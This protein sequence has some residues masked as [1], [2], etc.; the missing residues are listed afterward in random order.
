M[1]NENAGELLSYCLGHEDGCNR[2][3]NA[4][5]QGAQ[6]FSAAYLFPNRLNRSLHKRV[7]LPVTG[8]AA[9]VIYEIV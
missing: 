6:N 7:H 4:S 9:D 3:I 2:R 8:A 1:I 5:G